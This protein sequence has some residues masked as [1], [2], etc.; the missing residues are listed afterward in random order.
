[1]YVE[2]EKLKAKRKKIMKWVMIAIYILCIVLIPFN[3]PAAV[4]IA[5]MTAAISTIFT[6][7]KKE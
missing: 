7:T 5:I 6:L 3:F 2:N 4:Y 1:M